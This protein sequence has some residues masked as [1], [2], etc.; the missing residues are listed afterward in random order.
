MPPEHRWSEWLP[1]HSLGQIPQLRTSASY[2]EEI[3]SSNLCDSQFCTV[4]F[5]GVFVF[6]FQFAN[7]KISIYQSVMK[8]QGKGDGRF[9]TWWKPL[10]G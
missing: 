9:G 1:S 3:V 7:I 10:L 5:W 2:A 6:L 8:V 4:E